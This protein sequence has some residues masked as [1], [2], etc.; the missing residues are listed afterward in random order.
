MILNYYLFKNLFICS[1]LSYL[2]KINFFNH[3]LKK[4][5]CLITINHIKDFVKIIIFNLSN[6]ILIT[7]ILILIFLNYLSFLYS[8]SEII[9][10][11]F[12]NYFFLHHFSINYLWT[13]TNLL[14]I[15]INFILPLNSLS[16][17]KVFISLFLLNQFSIK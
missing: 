1:L 11:L 3:C 8:K 10:F 4:L 14:I 9:K 16:I 12:F 5:N 17:A 6:F 15:I 13:I 2:I 7:I